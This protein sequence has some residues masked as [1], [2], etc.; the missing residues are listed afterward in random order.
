MHKKKNGSDEIRETT[1]RHCILNIN[2]TPIDKCK[3]FSDQLGMLSLP[4]LAFLLEEAAR[5]WKDIG[6]FAEGGVGLRS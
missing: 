3:Q 4:G 6:L 2:N 1:G 5:W